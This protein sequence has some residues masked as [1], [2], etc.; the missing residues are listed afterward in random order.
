[1]TV[2]APQ[3]NDLTA[4]KDRQ[5]IFYG[6]YIVFAA[7]VVMTVSAGF[8]FY[9]LSVYLSAFVAER[10]FSVGYTSAATAAFFISSG[11]T[12]LVVARLIER[13]DPR[14]TVSAGAL[15]T[16]GVLASAGLVRE[17]W[18]LYLFY[19]LFGAGYS[20]CAL[21][22]C[23]T[24]VAR[25]FEK[26]RSV[27]LSFASTGLS[28]GGIL[29]TPLSVTLIEKLGLG[30]AAPWLG[31]GLFLGI[32]PV[33]IILFR[34]SP[35]SMGLAPD[36]EKVSDPT[37]GTPSGSTGV[38][39]SA[40]LRSRFFI[41]GTITFMTSML[42]QVGSI[43]H[44]FSLVLG[45]TADKE[46]AALAVSLMAGASIVGRLMG[47][48]ALPHLSSRLFMMALLVGQAAALSLYAFADTVLTLLTVAVLFG[49]TV[50]N[51]L[52]MQ[53]L[54][55]AEAFGTVAYA[56][57]YSTSQLFTTFGVASGPA[58]FGLIFET[59][60]GYTASYLYGA[61][62]SLVGL[63]ALLLAG[64]VKAELHKQTVK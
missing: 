41:F 17:L 16:A 49:F 14:W 33:S 43:A 7:F 13:Y 55:I 64:P 18:Q 11:V 40:A 32:V 39:Y 21:L 38:P 56:R 24:L 59:A 26:K 57:V 9:N 48:W 58:A 5:P 63:G 44:Q 12:G 3:M 28:L 53:P 6:W 8:G 4:E 36:G 19:I 27:A 34:P 60:G 25:W 42:A 51:L 1:M 23:T 62:A 2:S 22:P 46:T 35:A 52:M 47:G 50:G 54:L 61:A 20:A 29:L 37:E 31:V 10:G 30:G 45:R 15:M